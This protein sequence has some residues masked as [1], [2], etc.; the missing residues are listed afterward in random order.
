M[1]W[2]RPPIKEWGVLMDS[3]EN[4]WQA[5][6][7]MARSL[8]RRRRRQAV[9]TFVLLLLGAAAEMLSVSAV[10][11]FLTFLTKQPGTAPATV[12]N[13]LLNWIPEGADTLIIVTSGFIAVMLLTGLIRLALTWMTNS[14]SINTSLDLSAAAF[15]KITAQP[16]NFYLVNSSSQILSRFEKIQFT[17]III[18]SGVQAAVSSVVAL[19]LI[20]FLLMLDFWVAITLGSILI[21]SYII[22]SFVG[23]KT[24]VRNSKLVAE[25][26]GDRVQHI[27]QAI[28][29]IRDILLDRSQWVF[30]R[31][32]ERTGNQMRR[33]QV[34]N[35][36]M[37][38]APRHAIESVGM[39]AIAVVAVAVSDNEGGI[40]AALPVLGGLAIGAQRLVPLLQ[41]AYYGWSSFFGSR[42][43]FLEVAG[44]MALPGPT[45]SEPTPGELAFHTAIEFDRVS[46]GY[47][48]DRPVLRD[49]DFQIRK[50]E[51]IGIIGSTG[52][53]KTTLTDLLLGLLMPSEGRII[54][55]GRGLDQ[56]TM[57]AWRAQVAHV[58]QAIYLSDDTIARNIAF[59]VFRDEIDPALVE[60]A[61]QS[62]GLHKFILSLPERYQTRC[63]ERGIRLSGGQRQRIGIARALYKKA[64]ILV[65]DEATSALDNATERAV[66]ESISTL[67]SSITVIM[68]AHRLSSLSECNR[69][70]HVEN[71]SVRE[72]SHAEAGIGQ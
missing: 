34:V 30:Q 15:Q 8:P 65:L 46:Y 29:G 14:F 59:G 50:G 68:V 16:Y 56:G 63:G 20:I 32:F 22:I 11:T 3:V 35:S 64:T 9:L 26:L 52:S 43:T 67:S 45:M 13:P 38:W 41:Q 1:R 39:T 47:T 71:G 6:K 40:I 21:G 42:Q 60:S 27:Q 7:V 23:Q 66:M 53:G 33:P 61:A 58:P 5:V 72:V 24:L 19:L 57:S 36:F 31:D 62:A 10:Y 2:W 37:A 25:A 44:L 17:M 51:R 12:E 70:F 55:D 48:G 49:V 28:G 18:A 69:I 54:I 4:V